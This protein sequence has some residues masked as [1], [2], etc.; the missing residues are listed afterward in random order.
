VFEQATRSLPAVALHPA[1]AILFILLLRAVW[2]TPHASGKLLLVVVWLRYVMQAYHEVTYITV[3][4][5]SINALVSLAVCCVGVAILAKRLPDLGRYPINL[6]LVAAI[7]A[8]GLMNDALMPTIETVL[9][10][11]YFAVV[12]LAISDCIRRDG[13]ARI[14]GLLLWAFAP[15]LVYQA[16]SLALGVSK[17]TESD[18]SISYIGGYNHEAAFSVVLVT[19]FTIAALAHRLNPA[20]RLTLLVACLAGIFAA[21]YRTSLIALAPIAFGYFVFGVA[22]E[23]RR[24]QRIVF[25]LIGLLVM[26]GA[27]VAANLAMSDRLADLSMVA[28]ETSD[29]VRNPDEFTVAERELMSGR[30]YIWNRYFDEYRAGTDLQ[31]LLGFG[32]DAWMEMFGVYAHNTLVSYLYEFGLVGAGLIVLVWVAMIVR[33]LRVRDWTLRGQ[34]V[35]THIG[36]VLLNMATMPFWQIEGLIFYALLCGYTVCVSPGSAREGRAKG[37]SLTMTPYR[38][39]WA[40]KPLASPATENTDPDANQ[41]FRRLRPP[42]T[43]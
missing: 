18:G 34:L 30:L 4:G 39:R 16:L 21:N 17:A 27:A 7:V 5:V 19:C 28:T 36:F 37:A 15:P 29:L 3:G 20:L 8:S 1:T 32:A 33:A 23:A 31:L 41:R 42:R 25:S 24:G 38:V 14:L 35:C 10:W 11:G 13:D 26:A 40:A 43:T 6:S 9:K 12:F 22:R 2:K